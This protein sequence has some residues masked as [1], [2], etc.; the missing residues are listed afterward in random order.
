[1]RRDAIVVIDIEATCW[2]GRNNPPGQQSEIIEI[3]VVTLDLKTRECSPARSILVK[4]TRSKVSPF[5]TE[6]TTLTQEIVDTGV[7][8]AAACATLQTD[9][10]SKHCVWGSWGNYDRKMFQTQCASFGVDYPFSDGH[11]NLKWL[12]GKL[13]L[14]RRQIGMKSALERVGYE[15]N[16]THHRGDDDAHNIARLLQYMLEQRGD[17]ILELPPET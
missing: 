15:L 5:C 11:I 10:D 2:E 13:F 3:G 14:N 7:S 12:F 8:F 16:G 6:L 4:P 17:E 9:F 1:M